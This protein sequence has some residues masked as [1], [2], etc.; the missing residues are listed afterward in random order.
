[1][2]TLPVFLKTHLE[3]RAQFNTLSDNEKEA[4]LSDYLQDKEEKGDIPKK[5]SNTS[6]SKIIDFQIRHI[7][8]TV[9]SACYPD[10]L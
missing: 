9:C 7:T 8:S 2:I 1:M 4:L 3:L 10:I 6:L 5:L